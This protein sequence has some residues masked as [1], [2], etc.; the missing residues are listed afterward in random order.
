MKQYWIETYGCQMNKAESEALVVQLDESGWKSASSISESDVVILN[1][2]SVRQTAEERIWGRIGF[3]RREKKTRDFKLVVTGCMAE[4]LK[5][6]LIE[7][8]PEVDIVIGNFCK[9]DLIRYL[10]HAVVRDGKKIFAFNGDYHFSHIHGNG[11]FKAFIPIMHGCNNYCSYCIVPYVRGREI[12]RNPEEIIYEVETLEN[13]QYKEITLIGQNVNSYLH[14]NGASTIRFWELLRSISEHTRSIEWIRFLTSNPKDFP[15]QLISLIA[16]RENICKQIHLPVQHASDRLL[17]LMNRQYNISTYRT[18]IENIRKKVPDISISTDILIGFPGESDS[19]F[20]ILLDFMQD[21]EFNDAFMYKYNKRE[22]TK[23]FDMIDDVDESVKLER[24]KTVIDLQRK[25]SYKKR[26]E[27]IGKRVTVLPECIS[28]KRE[29]ELLGRT[30][31]DET[32]VFPGS[33][34]QIGSFREI[35]IESIAGNTL[36]GK[37]ISA[38]RGS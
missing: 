35:L 1:T 21:I 22:G 37:D 30:Q 11:S 29:G 8:A 24:L 34:D 13:K 20:Q 3:Y 31:Y 5:E 9:H 23:A 26:R 32:V 2:C 14:S 6:K 38:C 25:I 7:K 33:R 15:P 19:D 10:N 16:E 27:K 4:R 17:G 36:I 28:K 18:I 12:S